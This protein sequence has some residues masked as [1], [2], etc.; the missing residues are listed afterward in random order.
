VKAEPQIRIGNML[1]DWSMC[2]IVVLFWLGGSVALKVLRKDLPNGGD[3]TTYISV[4]P[5]VT[6]ISIMSSLAR[7]SS[8]LT[9]E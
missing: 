6:P 8:E 4:S 3:L 9:E 1:K 2:M 7:G 5:N